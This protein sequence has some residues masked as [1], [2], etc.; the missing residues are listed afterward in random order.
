MISLKTLLKL[1]IIVISFAKVKKTKLIPIP[2][3]LMI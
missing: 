1:Y 2:M 3:I